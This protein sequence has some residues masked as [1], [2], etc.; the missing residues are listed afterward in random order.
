MELSS[1][2]P[3]THQPTRLEAE[4]ELS[5]GA[6]SKGGSRQRRGFWC[7]RPT[8][9]RPRFQPS[10]PALSLP[11]QAPKRAHR[12]PR[13][14]TASKPKRAPA[15]D[16]LENTI[17]QKRPLE[18]PGRTFLSPAQVPSRGLSPST[19]PPMRIVRNLAR[20]DKRGNVSRASADVRLLMGSHDEFTKPSTNTVP[21][22]GTRQPKNTKIGMGGRE[23]AHSVTNILEGHAPM[24]RPDSNHCDR[25]DHG[26]RRATNL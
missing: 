8:A 5:K 21:V 14:P 17:R 6:T 20:Q 3:E 12:E 23:V 15:L 18:T 26:A 7:R 10:R 16:G 25:I 11:H 9:G 24:S 19:L 2:W 22:D 1:Y 13:H 4:F